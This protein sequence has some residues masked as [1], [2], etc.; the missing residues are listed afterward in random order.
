MR[1]IRAHE[2]TSPARRFRPSLAPWAQRAFSPSTP[3]ISPRARPSIHAVNKTKRPCLLQ[4][5]GRAG[6]PRPG[7]AA[8]GAAPRRASAAGHAH[9]TGNRRRPRPVCLCRPGEKQCAGV[10]PDCA[11]IYMHRGAKAEQNGIVPAECSAGQCHCSDS[12]PCRPRQA[13]VSYMIG[14]MDLDD[15]ASGM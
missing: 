6:L 13:F 11:P 1:L 15:V 4:D 12:E 8:D 2:A 5:A 9:E 14:H 10:V 7:L 3:V